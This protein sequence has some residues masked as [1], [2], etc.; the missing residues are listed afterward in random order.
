LFTQQR[1]DRGIGDIAETTGFSKFHLTPIKA[2]YHKPRFLLKT[3]HPLGEV[4]RR[5]LK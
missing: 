5:S 2:W 4:K 3:N 1:S